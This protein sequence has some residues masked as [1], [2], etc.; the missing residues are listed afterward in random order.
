MTSTYIEG[1]HGLGDNIRQ[2]AIVREYLKKGPV[3]LTSSWVSVYEDLIPQGLHIV[4]RPSSLR[5]QT[6]NAER[7]RERF[8]RV[9]IPRDATRVRV[10]YPPD[11][12]RKSGTILKA[13]GKATHCE[14]FDFTINVLAD[15]WDSLLQKLPANAISKP[16]MLYR[17][18]VDRPSDWGGCNARNPD[19]DAY[20][21]LFE[22]IRDQFYV[23]SVAD[24]QP[25]KE[26]IVGV[27][28]AVDYKFHA[29]ELSVEELFALTKMASL[30]Y[31][32]PGFAA[33]MAQA[34]G[35][36]VVCV[37]GGYER[38]SFFFDGHKIAPC[39]GID[40]ISP[41]DCFSHSHACEK[42][43]DIPTALRRIGAMFQGEGL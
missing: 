3:W 21:K 8:S 13:M 36:P 40:T 33:V 41:C 32:S 17:P 27:R 12:V 35:T 15:W 38:S 28:H 1:M 42:R 7:E 22:A 16:I 26:W 37:F 25:A 24:L 14:P 5:T 20:S 6:K 19:F 9:P 30:V 18:L 4:H 39:V 34:V 10:W 23:I 11:L 29:G 31:C 2:R 43:I